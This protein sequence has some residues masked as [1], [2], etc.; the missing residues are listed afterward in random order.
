MISEYDLIQDMNNNLML[1]NQAINQMSK[2]GKEKAETEAAYRIALA[3]KML[4]ERNENNTPVGMLS[5]ICRGDREIAL[6]KV[7]RDCADS[8]YDANLQAIYLYKKRVDI[9]QQQLTLEWG[10]Q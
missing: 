10:R 1:A 2:L 7:K 5:D 8:M 3:E 6:L 9:C 4:K